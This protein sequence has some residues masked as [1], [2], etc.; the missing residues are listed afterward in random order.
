MQV[1]NLISSGVQGFQDATS[2]A[3]EAAQEIASQVVNDSSEDSVDQKDLVNSLVDLKVAEIDAQ[4]NAKVLQTAS[5][6]VGS[7]LDV[8]A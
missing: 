1:N 3:N 7:L 4:A 2:R 6:L 8:T 5:D